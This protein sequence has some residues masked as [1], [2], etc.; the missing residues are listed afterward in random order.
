MYL[1]IIFFALLNC[2]TIFA[3]FVA[4]AEDFRLPKFAVPERYQLKILTDIILTVLRLFIPR[5]EKSVAGEK[6]LVSNYYYYYDYC[7]SGSKV[8]MIVAFFLFFL[9]NWNGSRYW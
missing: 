7:V 5:G 2:L 6:V 4:S 1:K 9:D 3:R 8:E